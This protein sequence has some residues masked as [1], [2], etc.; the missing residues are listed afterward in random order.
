MARPARLLL[1]VTGLLATSCAPAFR[2]L[3]PSPALREHEGLLVLHVDTDVPLAAIESS[4]GTAATNVARG[5]HAWIVRASAGRDRWTAIRL[6]SRAGHAQRHRLEGEEFGFDV[7]AGSIN[8]PGALVVR[9]NPVARSAPGH[10]RVR[11]LDRA[12]MALRM[13][14]EDHAGL[15]ASRPLRHAGAGR[16]GFLEH[17]ARERGTPHADRP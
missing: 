5:H 4:R 14:L 7:R 15:L 2:P 6:G 10:V 3:G 9:S 1:V 17:Y 8:Y 13:L 16:D 12:A 11:S